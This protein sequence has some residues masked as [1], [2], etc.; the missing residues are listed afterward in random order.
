MI[1]DLHAEPVTAG[2]ALVVQAEC[3][4]DAAGDLGVRRRDLAGADVAELGKGVL[5]Q[6]EMA[7]LALVAL[8]DDLDHPY[9]LPLCGKDNARNMLTMTLMVFLFGP[10]TS[11]H[12]PQAPPLFQRDPEKA[13]P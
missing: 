10:V 1:D 6:V 4:R 7:L 12:V 8:V 5:E 2:T 13:V 9:Q 11:R 3:R